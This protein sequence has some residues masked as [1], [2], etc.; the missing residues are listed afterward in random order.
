MTYEEFARTVAG[1]FD[2]EGVPPP[3]A[4]L[5]EDLGLDSLDCFSLVLLV[6]ELAGPAPA[7]GD[8]AYPVLLTMG[9][10]HHYAE[11]AQERARR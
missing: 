6:D 11:E 4:R 1:E 3:S 9:D 5:V 2:I 7:P 10:A 8:M